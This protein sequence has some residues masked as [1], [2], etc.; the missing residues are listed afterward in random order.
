MCLAHFQMLIWKSYV[1]YFSIILLPVT[2][3]VTFNFQLTCLS[4]FHLQATL[5]LTKPDK[6]CLLLKMSLS[7][8]GQL[9]ELASITEVGHVSHLGVDEIIF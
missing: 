2:Q 7:C 9:L 5:E 4:A 3:W 1:D 8:L 6:F